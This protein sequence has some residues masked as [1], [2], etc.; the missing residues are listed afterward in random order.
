MEEKSNRIIS[1]NVD[2]PMASAICYIPVLGVLPATA[3]LI[4]EKDEKLKWNALQSILLWVTVMVAGAILQI[5]IVLRGLI[6][7]INLLGLIALPL[8]MAVKAT[9]NDRMRLPII[10]HIVDNLL[11]QSHKITEVTKETKEKIRSKIQE[12]SNKKENV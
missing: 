2:E 1:L 7:L 12:S 4:L 3:F 10:A 8:V 6:P 9:Q 11:D 5:T